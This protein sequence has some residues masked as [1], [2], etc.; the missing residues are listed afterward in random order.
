MGF[1]GSLFGKKKPAAVA[2]TEKPP[3]PL[4]P[5]AEGTRRV[6]VL[7]FEN[8]YPPNLNWRE[9]VLDGTRHRERTGSTN[10]KTGAARVNERFGR[11]FETEDEAL[12]AFER[13]GRERG[14]WRRVEQSV[15]DVPMPKWKGTPA[16]A[17]NPEHEAILDAATGDA[18]DVAARVY[19][20][21]LV[22]Q[23]DPRGELAAL[24]QAGA[25]PDSFLEVNGEAVFGDLDVSIGTAISKLEWQGGFLRRA[26]L[27]QTYDPSSR[28][29]AELT[30]AFLALPITRFVTALRFG[31]ENNEGDNS[32]GAVLAAVANSE[33]GGAMRELAFDDYNRDDSE[34]SWVPVGELGGHWD[35]LRS[36]EVLRVRAGAGGTL[37]AIELPSLREFVRESGSL[38]ANELDEIVTA[39]WPNLERLEIWT[40]HPDYGGDTNAGQLRAFFAPGGFPPK[41]KHFGLVN[42]AYVAEVWPMLMASPLLTQLE[43]LDLSRGVLGDDNVELLL[44][45]A[46]TLAKLKSLDLNENVFGEASVKRLQA[47]LP[48]AQL[49]DQRDDEYRYVAVGE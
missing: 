1:L 4:G 35:K 28:P 27:R 31:L 48:N 49:H 24:I 39:K 33:R 32:W 5:P 30:A 44:G 8:T 25:S 43:S 15:R 6:S 40:G 10:T 11:I 37:G 7:R 18:F 20:D 12:A 47:A 34:L 19:A 41:L 16:P 45:A 2:E 21:W 29:L 42:C 17:L 13:L 46:P 23:N 14:T 26:S 9:V 3:Q 38:N 36:L 22:A